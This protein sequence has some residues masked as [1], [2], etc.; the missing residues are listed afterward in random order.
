MAIPALDPSTGPDSQARTVFLAVHSDPGGRS[1]PRPI[2]GGHD[3]Y[4]LL[5]ARSSAFRLL[6]ASQKEADD[7][8]AAWAMNDAG[9]S[10]AP[11]ADTVAWCQ[12]DLIPPATPLPTQALLSCIADVLGRAEL[13]HFDA[14]E[15]LIPLPEVR[16]E[17]RQ[18]L[19]IGRLLQGAQ[20]FTGLPEAGRARIVVTL[21]A[22]DAEG[23][24]SAVPTL[25][26]WMAPVQQSVI[27]LDPQPLPT[28]AASSFTSAVSQHLRPAPVMNRIEFEAVL[29]DWS[30]EAVGWFA[31]FLAE[32]PVLQQVGG[33]ALLTVRRSTRM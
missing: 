14:V 7:A 11:G 4:S 27:V 13:S 21:E 5:V 23:L 22:A 10:S 18:R 6:A 19:A 33:S 32:A 28:A 9:V 12:V 26:Q 16:P 15:L 8:L 29:A 2:P 3:L 1:A 20:W 17:S 31:A 30:L 24:E 25:R